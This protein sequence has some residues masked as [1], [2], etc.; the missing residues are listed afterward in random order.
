MT[1]AEYINNILQN[2]GRSKAWLAEQCDIKYKTF[3][4]KLFANRLSANEL[5]LISTILNFDLE[6]MK[7]KVEL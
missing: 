7:E 5:L 3:Y 2:Q 1:I 6:K 4:D